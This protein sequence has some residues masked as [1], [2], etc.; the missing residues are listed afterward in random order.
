MKQPAETDPSDSALVRRV[1]D[2]D[3]RAFRQLVDRHAPAIFRLTRRFAVDAPDADDLAQ[4]IFLKAY[5]R[6]DRFE[7]GTDFRAWLYTLGVN[8]CR[9]Y[10]KNIRRTVDPLSRVDA[11]RYQ[12]ALRDQARQDRHLERADD[13][14]A[15]RWALEQLS[16]EYATAF[17]LKYEEGLKYREISEML[18][19]SVSALKVRVHRARKQLKDL[20][21]DAR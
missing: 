5:E 9:D 14:A 19:D 8:H 18:G 1:R 12:H 7:A 15:L 3:Q 10:A 17:L 13:E 20:L 11:G 21:E 6:L 4:E 16:P 2:G